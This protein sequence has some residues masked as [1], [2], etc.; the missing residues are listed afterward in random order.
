MIGVGSLIDLRSKNRSFITPA[1]AGKGVLCQLIKIE[2]YVCRGG[3]RR[4]EMNSI[5]AHV[6]VVVEFA[7]FRYGVRVFDK[8]RSVDDL[9][10]SLR[11]A[12]RP[13]KRQF[14][15]L[16]FSDS[17][18]GYAHTFSI[19][20]RYLVYFSAK[21]VAIQTLPAQSPRA[22]QPR[23]SCLSAHSSRGHG[24]RPAGRALIDARRS[25]AGLARGYAT[26]DVGL[27]IRRLQ[28]P[29]FT[30]LTLHGRCASGMDGRRRRRLRLRAEH[31]SPAVLARERPKIAGALQATALTTFRARLH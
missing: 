26:E 11:W 15:G 3:C 19:Y 23:A 10:T 17:D 27:A 18:A 20:P 2:L 1:G 7:Q 6:A 8:G 21:A 29:L 25:T 31:D 13:S 12:L 9:A 5:S 4:C 28:T 30:H 16:R 14:S 24:T 22:C